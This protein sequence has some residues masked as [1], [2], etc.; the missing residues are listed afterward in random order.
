MQRVS[1]QGELADEAEQLS[2]EEIEKAKQIAVQ[3]C[4][5]EMLLKATEN[6][7]PE[8]VQVIIDR[9]KDNADL[10]NALIMML[11]NYQV[12]AADAWWNDYWI[13]HDNR[14]FYVSATKYFGTRSAESIVGELAGAVRDDAEF[15]KMFGL[16]ELWEGMSSRIGFGIVETVG[17]GL[18]VVGGVL[19]AVAPEP[20]MLTKAGGGMAVT[21]GANSV[22]SGVSSFGGRESR[23]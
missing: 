21:F 9:Y 6:S 23:S 10:Q 11:Q 16:W 8:I 3:A 15:Y 12:V 20:T 1:D 7:S 18:S 17:G 22:V 19:L 13:D 5:Q 2:A 4:A 14:K